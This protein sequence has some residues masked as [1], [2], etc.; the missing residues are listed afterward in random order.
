MELPL[1]QAVLDW[2]RAD[3]E[4]AAALNI[5]A[6]ENPVTATA[7]W[8]GIVAS[9]AVDWSTKDLAGREIRL[10]LEL[11]T[12]GDDA[13]GAIDLGRAIV[14]RLDAIPRAQNGCVVAS[15]HFLRSRAER[16][17]D[18]IRAILLEYRFRV[19]ALH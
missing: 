3:P 8:L 5:I 13:R 6:D 19:L 15:T 2:L 14:A 1:R 9:A 10:A 17:A 7:P 16:R 18:N 12:R 4:L 11:N